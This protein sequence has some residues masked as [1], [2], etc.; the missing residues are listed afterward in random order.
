V[1]RATTGSAGRSPAAVPPIRPSG[2]LNDCLSLV[3]RTLRGTTVRARCRRQE[4]SHGP[5]THRRGRPEKS[6]DKMKKAG[7]TVVEPDIVSM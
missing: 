5:S 3:G 6:I 2:R 4:E 7:I 1:N